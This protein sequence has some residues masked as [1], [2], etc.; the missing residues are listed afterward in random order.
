MI[1]LGIV[2]DLPSSLT[3]EPV[4]SIQL[5]PAM[6]CFVP[7]SSIMS[8]LHLLSNEASFSL[9]SALAFSA[10]SRNF[11]CLWCVCLCSVK[12]LRAREGR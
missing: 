9:A 3:K 7:H 2:H 6:V 8:V 10:F 5:R 11:G 4:T 12:G 1:G